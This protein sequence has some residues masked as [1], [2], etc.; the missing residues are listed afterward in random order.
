MSTTPQRAT[1]IT[2]KQEFN[3]DEDCTFCDEVRTDDGDVLVVYSSVARTLE[4]EL[5]DV[6]RISDD[7]SRAATAQIAQL[8]DDHETVRLAY[9]KACDDNERLRADLARFTGDGLLD[10]HAICDQRDKAVA[11]RD[12]LRAERNAI[13]AMLKKVVEMEHAQAN[14]LA[15]LRE[16]KARLDL[17]D[18][19]AQLRERTLAIMERGAD[20]EPIRWVGVEW[21]GLETTVRVA[22]DFLRKR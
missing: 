18:R 8:R 13:G 20:H 14:E 5:A 9:V 12:Q 15:T 16:D 2:D 6:K 10:C 1:P 11:K 21:D 7:L 22:I 19:N 3:A 4:R 17:L